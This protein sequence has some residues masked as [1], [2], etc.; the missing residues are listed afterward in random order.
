MVAFPIIGVEKV[1]LFASGRQADQWMPAQRGIQPRRCTLLGAN[2]YEVRDIAICALR[3][4]VRAFAINISTLACAR[5]RVLEAIRA[6]GLCLRRWRNSFRL[7]LAERAGLFFFNLKT[8]KFSFLKQR[9]IGSKLAKRAR[10]EAQV[11]HDQ[12]STIEV[13]QTVYDRLC[14]NHQPPKRAD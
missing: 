8:L 7:D 2:T 5:R 13:Y 11:N 3:L 9:T 4:E 14:N 1:Y 12:D 6:H 10:A